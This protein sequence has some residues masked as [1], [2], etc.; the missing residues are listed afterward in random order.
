M[1]DGCLGR[2]RRQCQDGRRRAEEVVEQARQ[3]QQ[4]QPEPSDTADKEQPNYGAVESGNDDEGDDISCPK[5]EQRSG[6]IRPAQEM[7]DAV[8]QS[9]AG[10]FMASNE[11]DKRAEEIIGRYEETAKTDAM[12]TQANQRATT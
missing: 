9:L 1:L 7:A 6:W 4:A 12:A 8:L 5:D 3:E 2:R 10:M 11:N